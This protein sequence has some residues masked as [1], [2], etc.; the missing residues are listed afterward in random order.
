MAVHY[1]KIL[2]TRGGQDYHLTIHVSPSFNHVTDFAVVVHYAST[3]DPDD[4]I[5]IARI[6]TAHGYPHFDRLYRRDQPKE[7]IDADVW[8][9]AALLEENWRTYA[10]S[11]E[12]ASRE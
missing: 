9:A 7:R 5:Q 2:G 11:F 10:E 6:D 8:E 1:T 12:D 4:V 3:D